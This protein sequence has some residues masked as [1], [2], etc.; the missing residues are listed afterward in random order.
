MDAYRIPGINGLLLV[1]FSRWDEDTR[2]HVA[3]WG[4]VRANSDE[5]DRWQ[6]HAVDLPRHMRTFAA[7]A[8]RRA[9]VPVPLSLLR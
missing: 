8:L 6:N 1:P 9:Q 3:G 4:V 7:E 2:T 5:F